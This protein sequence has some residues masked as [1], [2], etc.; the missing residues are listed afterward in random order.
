MLACLLAAVPRSFAIHLFLNKMDAGATFA[1]LCANMDVSI[2]A[3]HFVL[4]ETKGNGSGVWENTRGDRVPELR[5]EGHMPGRPKA[6]ELCRADE[7]RSRP[8]SDSMHQPEPCH[9]DALED[10]AASRRGQ[11]PSSGPCPF[12]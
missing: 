5:Q 9:E 10:R 3:T 11:A 8:R 1:A 2:I 4:K 12:R 6:T 7:R